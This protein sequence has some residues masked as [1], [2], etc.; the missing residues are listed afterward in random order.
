MEKIDA[1][2][3][4]DGYSF[5]EN[6]IYLN[7]ATLSP[8]N[9]KTTERIEAALKKQQEPWTQR[10]IESIEANEEIKELFSKMINCNSN[11]IARCSATSFAMSCIVENLKR[12]GYFTNETVVGIL[13]DQFPSMIFAL[14]TLCEEKMC[15]LRKISSDQSIDFTP[16]ILSFLENEKSAK[17][18]ILVLPT[19]HWT[20]GSYVNLEIIAEKISLLNLHSKLI[21]IVDGTQTL[22][23]EPFDVNVVKPDFLVCSTYKWLNGPRPGC[24]MYISD[25]WKTRVQPLDHHFFTRD[26]FTECFKNI[27]SINFGFDEMKEHLVYSNELVDTAGRLDT[28]WT[29]NLVET[30]HLKSSLEELQEYGVKKVQDAMNEKTAR[31]RAI[32]VKFEQV[33]LPSFTSSNILGA[34]GKFDSE[35]GAKLY[36]FLAENNIKLSCRSGFCRFA[37]YLYTTNE[38]LDKLEGLIQKFFNC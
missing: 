32:L 5:P 14:Q 36:K 38:D 22:G 20:N 19:V 13:V 6:L 2:T 23:V 12:L 1:K 15:T 31:I 33:E 10:E 29:F 11:N 7:H 3:I 18:L 17:N 35:L 27:A 28:G 24:L 30:A 25:L 26:Y 34:R 8:I 21:L 37:P 9:S 16:G 4:K